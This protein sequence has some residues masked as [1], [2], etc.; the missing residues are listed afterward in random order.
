MMTVAQ[1]L[2]KLQNY[3]TNTYNTLEQKGATIPENKTMSNIVSCIESI[4]LAYPNFNIYGTLTRNKYSFSNFSQSNYIE[5]IVG[6][7][8][9]Q[10]SWEI[11]F[12][13]T[14][15]SISGSQGALLSSRNGQQQIAL[16]IGDGGCFGLWLGSNGSSFDIFGYEGEPVL[17]ANVHY[18]AKITFNAET[19]DYKVLYSTDKVNW[20]TER[21]ENSNL[22]LCNSTQNFVYGLF[23]DPNVWQPFQGIIHMEDCYIKIGNIVTWSAIGN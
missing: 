13:F 5:N 16:H 14:L 8:P 15:I 10:N 3:L 22:Y 21:T 19:H 23:K 9:E 1:E 2:Q 11:G 20:I 12:G 17:S 6:F 18:Y 4:P 7:A